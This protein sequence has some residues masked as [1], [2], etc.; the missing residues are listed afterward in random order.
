MLELQLIYPPYRLKLNYTT[1]P[2]QIQTTSNIWFFTLDYSTFK[3]VGVS[4]CT[5]EITNN[6]TSA[7]TFWWEIRTVL[8]TPTGYTLTNTPRNV[9]AFVRSRCLCVEIGVIFMCVSIKQRGDNYRDKVIVP[10]NK[11]RVC[12]HHV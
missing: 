3:M 6:E 2:I 9:R 8:R 7:A 12:C 11:K 10:G 5:V 4:R 1:W